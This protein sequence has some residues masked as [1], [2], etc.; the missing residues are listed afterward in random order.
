MRP[1]LEA[2]LKRIEDRTPQPE[3][4]SCNWGL[5]TTPELLR[6]YGAATRGLLTRKEFRRW[7][8]AARA[9]EAAGL[10]VEDVRERF[11]CRDGSSSL[12]ASPLAD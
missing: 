8:K 4:L 3:K 1:N 12:E 7:V 11:P 6:V 9:R 10:T 5:L 2:R